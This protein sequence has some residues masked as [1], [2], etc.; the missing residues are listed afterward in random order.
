MRSR[1]IL[2]LG[3]FLLCF[4]HSIQVYGEDTQVCT[5]CH[6][7]K[8][9]MKTMGG[10]GAVSL[11][12]D[13][14]Q[15]KDS[16]HGNLGC[17]S[18]HQDISMEDHPKK[19]SKAGRTRSSTCKNCHTAFQGIHA[20]LTGGKTGNHACTDC[21]GAHAVKRV[22]FTQSSDYCLN[23][24]GKAIHLTLGD[25]SK[26]SL[27]VDRTHIESSV[28]RKLT[29]SDCHFGFSAKAHPLR[30]FE[31]K[32]AYTVASAVACRR[33][34]YKEYTETFES[35]HNT[36]AGGGAACSDCHGAHEIVASSVLRAMNPTL[37][38]KCHQSTQDAFAKSVHGA[39]RIRGENQDAPTCLNCHGAHA[40]S[41]PK[42]SAF[43]LLVP[44][45]C[46][47]CHADEKRIGKYGI[48]STVVKT[49]N[50]DF[51]GITL[52]FYKQ[53][54]GTKHPAVCTDCHGIH[55]IAG[56]NQPNSPKDKA[57][58]EYKCMRCHPDAPAG[59]SDSSIP[60]YQ[61]S[62]AM[63]PTVFAINLFY[64]LFIGLMVV[65]LFVQ[66]L[67]H[68]WRIVFKFNEEENHHGN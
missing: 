36:V 61:A 4:L 29:C 47:K 2:L 45:M 44:E 52:G 65:G 28:H 22:K 49:Y 14:A 41:N 31:S 11:Y 35:V 8:E 46:G 53:K 39:A 30:E 40:I 3:V 21:H 67:L 19:G 7:D 38:A 57:Y 5:D 33:C 43:H 63:A 37:C 60:H 16:V 32:R 17:S 23:C 25:G 24:H 55:D 42:S 68:I 1:V 58:L 59:F 62:F 66:I 51:H 34:H 26:L 50:Q 10:P 9:I 15:L 56:L 13:Q 64:K 12:V 27:K 18:C 54:V 6:G 20:A 48:S